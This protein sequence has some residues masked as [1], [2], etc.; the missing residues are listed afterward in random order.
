MNYILYALKD[1]MSTKNR[2]RRSR[3]RGSLSSRYRKISS[4]KNLFLSRLWS[5]RAEEEIVSVLDD[6]IS[7]RCLLLLGLSLW[8]CR[9]DFVMVTSI[10]SIV[11]SWK[12]T[13]RDT[14]VFW[15]SS[16][17]RAESH[18][19]RKE[20]ISLLFHNQREGKLGARRNP[21]NSVSW[22]FIICT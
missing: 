22:V 9:T 19:A 21:S 13:R 5:L 2:R 15:R 8:F 20:R 4:F 17:P 10:H 7:S 14:F 11:G 16:E 12:S 3:K 6:V 18:G 1:R